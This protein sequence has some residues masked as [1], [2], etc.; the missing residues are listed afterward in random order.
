MAYNKGDESVIELTFNGNQCSYD[1]SW[2]SN[3]WSGPDVTHVIDIVA[4]KNASENEFQITSHCISEPFVIASSRKK[5]IKPLTLLDIDMDTSEKKK[6]YRKR[7]APDDDI[8]G[9]ETPSHA[10]RFTLY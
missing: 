8:G 10:V 9:P 7:T 3:R 2:K 5:T 4:M 1:Y 6:K